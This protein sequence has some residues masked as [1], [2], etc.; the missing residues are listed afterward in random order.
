MRK[1]LFL[2]FFMIL[3][4]GS[5]VSAEDVYCGDYQ[6][7]P[8][9]L[10]TESINHHL[11]KDDGTY[12]VYTDENSVSIYQKYDKYYLAHILFNGNLYETNNGLLGLWNIE[13]YKAQHSMPVLNFKNNK[14]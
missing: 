7:K 6:G 9:Y 14:F 11:I 10:R 8:V 2:A 1:I 3:C 5:S 4:F 13:Q 12:N